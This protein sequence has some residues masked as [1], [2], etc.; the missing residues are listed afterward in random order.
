[1]HA[2]GT[3]TAGFSWGIALLL[4]AAHWVVAVLASRHNAVTFDEVAHVAGGMGQVSAQKNHQILPELW[5]PRAQ[6]MRICAAK[7]AGKKM[8]RKHCSLSQSL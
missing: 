5:L 7:Q 2:E 1:M 8:E 3:L 6:R 4:A